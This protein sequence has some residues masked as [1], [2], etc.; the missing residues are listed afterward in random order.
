M[1]CYSFVHAFVSFIPLTHRHWHTHANTYTHLHQEA[2]Y[3]SSCVTDTISYFFSPSMSNGCDSKWRMPGVGRGIFIVTHLRTPSKTRDS[4]VCSFACLF[5]ILQNTVTKHTQIRFS[6]K[7]HQT[8]TINCH[9]SQLKR[10]EGGVV[11]FLIKMS[12]E[13][14]LIGCDG[15]GV[16]LASPGHLSARNQAFIVG[17][18]ALRASF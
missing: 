12:A 11:A 17:E 2:N 14:W 5:L 6:P 4:C 1:H 3:C 15:S 16:R 7:L 8:I 13:K 18:G 10:C 9:L